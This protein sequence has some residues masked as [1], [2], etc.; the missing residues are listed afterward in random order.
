MSENK[1]IKKLKGESTA[2]SVLE[3]KNQSVNTSF[4]NM[5]HG[6]SNTNRV[7]ADHSGD[8]VGVLQGAENWK[9]NGSTLVYASSVNSDGNDYTGESDQTGGSVVLDGDGMAV[10]G[11]GLWVNATYTFTGDPTKT[12]AI[13]NAGTKWALKLC[14][15]SLFSDN[16]T[17]DLTVLIKIGT[18]SVIS[19]VF[20]VTTD[21][22]NFCKDLVIDFSESAQTITKVQGN[23]TLKLQV[24]CSDTSASAT[25]YNGMTVLT[26]LVRK[27]DSNAVASNTHTFDDLSGDM[28]YVKGHIIVK[29]DTMPTATADLLGEMYQYTGTTSAPYEHGY[30]YECVEVSTGV[31]DWK[32]VDV[33]PGGSRGRF[34]ALW[35]SATGL[36]ETNPPISPYEYKTGDYFIVGTV[37]TATPAVNYKPDGTSYVTGTAST[38]VESEQVNIDDTYFFDG[39]NWK[40]QSNNAQAKVN[41]NGTSIMTGP[42]KMASGSMRGAFSPYLNGVGFFKMDAQNNMTQIATLSDTQFLP[43]TTSAISLGSSTKRFKDLYVGGTGSTIDVDGSTVWLKGYFNLRNQNQTNALCWCAGANNDRYKWALNNDINNKGFQYDSNLRALMPLVDKAENLGSASFMWKNVY[44]PKL[45][46]G[47]DIAVPTSG[48]TMALTSDI[49]NSTITISLNNVAQDTFTLNQSTNKT[50]NIAAANTDLNNLTSTGA[51]IANWSSNVTNCITEIPQDIQLELNDGVLTLKAGSKYYKPDGT[52]SV[53]TTDYNIPIAWNAA[54]SGIIVIGNSSYAGYAENRQLSGATN[55]TG[56]SGNSYLFW[57]TTENKMYW[58][59]NGGST[60]TAAPNCSVPIARVTWGA[61]NKVTSI[62]EIYNG[63]GYMGSTVF[64]LPG[65]SGLAP[66]GRNTDGTL[67]NQKRT[68]SNFSVVT[69]AATTADVY[70]AISNTGEIIWSQAAVRL[71][72]KE[73][74]NMWYDTQTQVYNN[75]VFF[76]RVKFASSHISEFYP[77]TV[78]H[79]V[80]YSDYAQTKSDV[81]TNAS[82]IAAILANTKSITAKDTINSILTTTGIN[83]AQSGYVKL[84]NGIIIQWMT[85]D[86]DGYYTTLRN[87]STA[88]SATNSYMALAGWGNT[89][90]ESAYPVTVKEQTT[91]GVYLQVY[92]G[93]AGQGRKITVI[94]IGY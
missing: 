6:T 29:S 87:W 42:L 26:A 43:A 45:N 67:K 24:L 16:K 50:I 80:D 78:F 17:I 76:A 58:T 2:K 3:I 33:Q 71:V 27:V 47:A 13:F 68:V 22:F 93:L 66:N 60:W 81:S 52:Y 53:I 85:L 69:S 37:I 49:K 57:N 86:W 1:F 25:I 12:V 46:N 40:L 84:G 54:A 48:G 82:D 20:T 56:L 31:Y 35:N 11:A 63:F 92:T 41:V 28:D 51:N 5:P 83:K 77:A 23:E 9:L 7:Y 72:Y 79:A 88:F 19:K 75:T 21:S 18:S 90:T 39:T 62:D 36:A 44:T 10:S 70:V 94:G 89:Q 4:A 65:L 32:R 59:T 73:P 64:A 38:V 91:T 14:G 15:H 34:L 61:D 8:A 30:I 55:P 74:E